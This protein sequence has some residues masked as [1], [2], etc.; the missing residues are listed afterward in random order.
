MASRGVDPCD[1]SAF[2]VKVKRF[3][4]KRRHTAGE[5]VT[6]IFRTTAAVKVRTEAAYCRVHSHF[7][8]ID[9]IEWRMAY[10]SH[11]GA[12]MYWACELRPRLILLVLHQ[13]NSVGAVV[14]TLPSAGRRLK[15]WDSCAKFVGST[16]DD[17]G[18]DR[19]AVEGEEMVADDTKKGSIPTSLVNQAKLE[20]RKYIEELKVFE[21]VD[22]KMTERCKLVTT[23][24]VL[25]NKGT[26][27]EPDV[28]ARWAAQE[29]KWMDGL[30]SK[31]HAPTLGLPKPQT[32]NP[33][34]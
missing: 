13:T 28:Q 15:A 14:R 29:F 6:L 3:K 34:P 18:D 7:V 31:H 26:V 2:N 9:G 4:K 11:R 25:T 1:V 21:V 24:W 19:D 20:E 22:R 12:A 23:R 5:A 30:D 27:E 16:A 32:E 10:S 8:T 17:Q 33:K